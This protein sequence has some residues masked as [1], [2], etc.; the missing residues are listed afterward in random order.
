MSQSALTS[1]ADGSAPTVRHPST[2]RFIVRQTAIKCATDLVCAR[3][4]DIEQLFRYA[5]RITA[6][7]YSTKEDPEGKAAAT[8]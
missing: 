6:W 7:I 2:Q 1:P 8:Q 4:V 5:G 3:Q